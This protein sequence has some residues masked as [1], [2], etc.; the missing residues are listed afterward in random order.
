[1]HIFLLSIGSF[2]LGSCPFSLL[3]GKILLHKDIRNY[4]DGN[5]GA[6][7]VF[8]TGSI[9]AGSIA[10]F[11]DVCKGIPFVHMAHDN[12][13]LSGFPIAIIAICAILG[14]AFSPFL[15]FKGGKSI[16]IT[17]GTLIGMLPDFE[18]LVAFII[19]IAIGAMIIM[20]D[21]WTV[22]TAPVGTLVYLLFTD[23]PLWKI[24]F[25]CCVLI[26]LVFK[27][28]YN[29]KSSPKIGFRLLKKIRPSI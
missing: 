20:D 3:V 11:L 14:S 18:L 26:I 5:P 7:N 8:R 9:P 21:A 19:F 28:R 23:T 16:A 17:F 27:H 1:M 10:A 2:F 29:L 15:L 6:V 4:G 12:Y 24:V 13:G 22:I 25:V